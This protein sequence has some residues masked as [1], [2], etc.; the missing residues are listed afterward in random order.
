[1]VS[2]RRTLF[3]AEQS[4]GPT[5]ISLGTR[6]AGRN[7]SQATQPA[8]ESAQSESSPVGTSAGE[9]RIGTS[10]GSVTDPV[11]TT[12]TL[13]MESVRTTHRVVATAILRGNF[14]FLMISPGWR[15]HSGSVEMT[16]STFSL[17]AM[18]HVRWATVP[19][20]NIVVSVMKSRMTTLPAMMNVNTRM[21]SLTIITGSVVRNVSKGKMD[22]NG[23]S[24]RYY[25]QLYLGLSL[26][27][28]GNV[29]EL[30]LT[31]VFLATGSVLLVILFK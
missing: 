20:G 23:F 21:C 27:K 28:N 24:L 25:L 31:P 7:V 9:R 29:T 3:S 19:V 10:T 8:K 15:I 6:P 11:F 18:E 4:V 1:M 12:S 5:T 2:A 26:V 30:V 13:A 14:V 22:M 16:A 17:S